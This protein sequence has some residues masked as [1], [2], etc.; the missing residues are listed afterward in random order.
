M[1][2]H[3]ISDLPLR[4]DLETKAVLK[5]TLQASRLL[6]ELKGIVRTIPNENIIINSLTLQEAQDSSAVENIITTQDELYQAELQ[7]DG[8]VSLATKEVQRYAI[9]LRHGFDQISRQKVI[10]LRNILDIQAELEQNDAGLRTLPGTQLKNDRTGEVVYVPPQHPDEIRRL[11]HNL[12]DFINDDRLSDLDPLVKMAIIHHQF[13]SIH[14][15]YDGNGRTGRILNILYLI[16]QELLDLP[17]L[18]LSQ[19]I[20]K[21]KQEYYRLLQLVREEQDWETWILYILK[22]VK[23]TAEDTIHLIKDFKDLMQKYK[24]R[25]RAE[26]PKIYSQDLLNNIFRHPYTKIEFV[27]TDLQVSRP[28]ATSYLSKLVEMGFL[29][30]H[31][32]GRSYYYVN[33]QLI[34]L[35]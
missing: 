13:E 29:N 3:Q 35:L 20:I 16:T 11:L 25:L 14:P 8:A 33:T 6:A 15:F 32:L 21:N 23:E 4:R 27:M 34:G 26:A 28:T 30:Q 19:F 10:T 17:I 31:K 9:A 1:K 24:L 22:G 12:I 18:Y 2:D 5:A 7:L